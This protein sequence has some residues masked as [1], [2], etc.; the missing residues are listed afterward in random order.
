[1]TLKELISK[2]DYDYIEFRCLTPPDYAEETGETEAFYG[3]GYS[4]DGIFY[5][6]DH[7][8]YSLEEELER[9]EEWSQSGIGNGLTVVEK[10]AWIT[11]II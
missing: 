10:C 11:T 5:P 4:K 2:K 6:N 1:M 7:D 3:S 9:W 8:S